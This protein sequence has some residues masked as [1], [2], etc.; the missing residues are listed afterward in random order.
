[1]AF[2]MLLIGIATGAAAASLAV[3]GWAAGQLRWIAAHCRQHVTYW[4]EE[5]ERAK[6]TAAWLREQRAASW[7]NWPGQ[8][9]G[10]PH[11]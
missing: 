8:R 5:A 1:M 3:F 7:Y 4:R 11:E 6:A 10:D 2:L 9:I